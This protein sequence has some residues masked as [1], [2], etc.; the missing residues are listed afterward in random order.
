M[1]VCTKSWRNPIFAF[2]NRIPM[3]LSAWTEVTPEV[4]II[5]ENMQ[6]AKRRAPLP[7]GEPPTIAIMPLYGCRISTAR[8]ARPKRVHGNCL[9]TSFGMVGW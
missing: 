6:T 4:N 9:S 5:K 2:R 8:P 1:K 3:K 7:L